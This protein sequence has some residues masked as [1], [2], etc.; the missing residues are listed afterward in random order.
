[1][2][3]LADTT[4]DVQLDAALSDPRWIAAMQLEL[5]AHEKNGTWELVN[6]PP[7]EKALSARWVLREKI[8]HSGNTKFK[9]R[10]VARGNEQR[11]GLDY[12]ET[13]APVVK[14]TTVRLIVALAAALG[15][16]LSHMDVVTA[17]LNGTLKETIFMR[18]PPG[19]LTPG[20]EE[21]VCKLRRSIYGLKQSPRAWY[22]EVDSFLRSIGCRRSALDSNLYLRQQG[23]QTAIILLF[24]DDLLITGNGEQLIQQLKQQL[25]SKYEMKDLGTA[26][27]H[28]GVDFHI[29]QEGILL[30]QKF[31]ADQLVLD[32][33]MEDCKAASTPLPEGLELSAETGTPDIDVTTYCKL[34]GK[35]IYLTNTRPDLSFSVGLVSRFMSQP[36][37]AHFDAAMHIV[38]YIKGTSDFGV[39]YK[40]GGPLELQGYTDADWGNS[41]PDTR[42]STGGYVH[43]LAGGPVTWSSKRQ[44]TVS[45]STTEAEYRALSDGAQEGVYLKRLVEELQ[46]CSLAST[47]LKCKDSNIAQDLEHATIPTLQDL[48]MHCDNMSSIKLA[49]N[50]VFHARTKHLEIHHHFI[51][52]RV[53]EGEVS[54]QHVR[55]EDQVA[56]ILTKVLPKTKFDRNRTQLGM[57]A[58]TQ[59][60]PA[61]SSFIKKQ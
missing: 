26:K 18:Q 27:R 1:M 30:H 50:P 32:Y 54:I 2:A 58:L 15:W 24:V 49:K 38:R 9:A 10:V 45:H 60:T 44:P 59:V 14:W 4:N 34:V 56:D 31:Y 42:R 13:F 11:E 23:D 51:R 22:E 7:G 47:S 41:C 33:G 43:K 6:L 17:F 36:Q 39:F 35:F 29:S 28:L 37:Q 40:R 61:L 19:F 48:Q 8:D 3:L 57:K 52:E 21:L 20:Q 55:S 5:H 16:S 46:Q 12:E 53:L 25:Q